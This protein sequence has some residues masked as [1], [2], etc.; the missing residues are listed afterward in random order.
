MGQT[1]YVSISGFLFKDENLEEFTVQK[2]NSSSVYVTQEGDKHP[3]RLDK[4]TLTNNS[5]I[6]GCYKAYVEPNDY[7]NYINQTK[8][9]QGLVSRISNKL[10]TLNIEQLKEIELLINNKKSVK[11]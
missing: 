3:I 11:V 8:E 1:L 9:K 4:K 5:G 7:W 2:I 10:G 6:L